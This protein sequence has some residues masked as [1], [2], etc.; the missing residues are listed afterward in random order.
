MPRSNS[1][2]RGLVLAG[3]IIALL[4]GCGAGPGGSDPATSS[5]AASSTAVSSTAASSPQATV[6]RVCVAADAF[7]GALRG[8]KESLKPGVRSADIRS[9]RDQVAKTYEDLVEASA[10]V[11]QDRVQ[12]VE[13]ATDDFRAAVDA[14]PEGAT[15]TAAID[16]L[17][18][19]ASDVQTALRG[20][21][22]ELDC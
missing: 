17:R 8:F 5:T 16:S 20:L 9:A 11:A 18:A 4:S 12:A 6:S 21:T 13:S 2:L 7:A 10:D 14:I 15:A 1:P 3:V 19:E 22:D